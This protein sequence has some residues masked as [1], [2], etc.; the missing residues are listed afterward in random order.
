MQQPAGVVVRLDHVA[1]IIRPGVS[2]A[3]E[4]QRIGNQ[5]DSAF[6]WSFTV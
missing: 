1:S 3:T 4:R 5:I 6:H 2:E